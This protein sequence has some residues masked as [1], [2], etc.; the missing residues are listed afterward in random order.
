VITNPSF[1]HKTFAKHLSIHFG[2]N[3]SDRGDSK[4]L[5]DECIK[6]TLED[7]TDGL[8]HLKVRSIYDFDMDHATYRPDMLAQVAAHCSGIAR[9][10][11]R[12]D[13]DQAGVQAYQDLS[14]GEADISKVYP[15]CWHPKYGGWFGIRCLMIFKDIATVGDSLCQKDPSDKLTSDQIAEL[16]YQYNNHWADWGW[17]DVGLDKVEKYSEAQKQYFAQ[18]PDKRTEQF[19]KDILEKLR[20]EVK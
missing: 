20:N 10:Y 6:K 3:P 18:S 2:G 12:Q 16:L 5:F 15:V 1:F 19:V 11:R 4:D 8:K 13:L 9:C 17:R 7:L 14:G